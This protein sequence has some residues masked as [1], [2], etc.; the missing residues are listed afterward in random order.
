MHVFLKAPI[1][2]AI[3]R[4]IRPHI[5]RYLRTIFGPTSRLDLIV[6]RTLVPAKAGATYITSIRPASVLVDDCNGI[7]DGYLVTRTDK[8]LEISDTG[9]SGTVPDSYSL[10]IE[11]LGQC[12]G[13]SQLVLRASE[14]GLTGA[15]QGEGCTGAT[16]SLPQDLPQDA[17]VNTCGYLRPQ[18]Q[19]CEGSPSTCRV[20]N[21]EHECT[22]TCS[23]GLWSCTAETVGTECGE[24]SQ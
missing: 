5:R 11:D 20:T 12:E 16:R 15:P 10:R 4:A 18:N 1:A 2:S 7:L 23:A 19:S 22:C 17:E 21:W 6:D 13:H 14:L 8:G 24:P 3:P 9:W